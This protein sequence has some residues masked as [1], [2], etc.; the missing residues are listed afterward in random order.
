M[1]KKRFTSIMVNRQDERV[2]TDHDEAI[3]RKTIPWMGNQ[4]TC[5]LKLQQIELKKK[6]RQDHKTHDLVFQL[7]LTLV[8]N[9]IV[10]HKY[11]LCCVWLV[12]VYYSLD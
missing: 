10:L 9:F 1:A 3:I 2:I 12:L 5:F 6:N 11:A 7:R 4:D 8:T